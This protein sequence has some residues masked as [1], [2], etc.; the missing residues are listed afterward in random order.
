MRKE[1]AD[2]AGGD[3]SGVKKKLESAAEEEAKLRKEE[4]DAKRKQAEE[5][6]AAL[7]Q[8]AAVAPFCISHIALAEAQDWRHACTR[9]C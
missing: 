7:R 3:V 1:R 5:E 6:E 4:Q 9:F 8:K 2:V